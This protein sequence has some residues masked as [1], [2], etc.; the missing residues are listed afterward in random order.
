MNA[1]FKV[2]FRL[3]LVAAGL[4]FAASLALVAAV[5]MLLWGLRAVWCKLTGQ[6]IN[7]FSVRMSPRSGLDGFLRKHP[8][9]QPQ[10]SPAKPKRAPLDDV[11]DVEAKEIAKPPR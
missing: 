11:T 5:L 1:V 3:V 6:P 7:P 2:L 10:D 8:A 4:V 9:P